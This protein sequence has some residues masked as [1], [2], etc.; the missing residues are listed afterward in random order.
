ME[1]PEYIR[2][3][4]DEGAVVKS[5]VKG[6]K[7][8]TITPKGKLIHFGSSQYDHYFDETGIWKD[9]DHKDKERMKNYVKRHSAIETKDGGKAIE[10]L[11]QPASWSLWVLWNPNREF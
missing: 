4:I 1:M 5:T 7:L 9:K 6:K 2:I 11:E 10:D 3:S 8:M